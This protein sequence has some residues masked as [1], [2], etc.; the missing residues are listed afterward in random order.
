MM[1]YLCEGTHWFQCIAYDHTVYMDYIDLAVCC[2]LPPSLTLPGW[3]LCFCRFLRLRLH[4]FFIPC[5]PHWCPFKI[6]CLS[7]W[8]WSIFLRDLDN[9]NWMISDVGMQIW[10][11]VLLLYPSLNEVEG[12]YIGFTLSVCPSVRPLCIFYN[13]RRIQFI[14]THLINFRRCVACN[15]FFKIKKI[16]VWANSWNL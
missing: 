14:F 13:T 8:F 2:P 3:L 6:Y 5:W 7:D 15:D 10:F 11:S 12:G 16:E 4:T 9:E 1:C